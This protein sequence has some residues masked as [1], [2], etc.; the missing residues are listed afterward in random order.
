MSKNEYPRD[1]RSASSSPGLWTELLSCA[2]NWFPWE[3]FTP[4]LN[5]PFD[6]WVSS[7]VL[8]WPRS[9]GAWFLQLMFG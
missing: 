4:S 1:G 7:Y 9:V 3:W 5:G 2:P 8:R 6:R